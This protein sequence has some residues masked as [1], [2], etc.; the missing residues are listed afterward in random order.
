MVGDHLQ[1]V[2]R[3][4]TP[5]SFRGDTPNGRG[6]YHEIPGR[7]PPKFGSIPP[8]FGRVP[9]PLRDERPRIDG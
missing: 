3:G 6:G 8:R 2:T 4:D 1:M 7:V 5:H 9:P